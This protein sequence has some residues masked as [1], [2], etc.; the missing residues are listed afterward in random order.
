MPASCGT[1][2]LLGVVA[3]QVEYPQTL[4]GEFPSEYAELPRALISATL[5]GYQKY[6]PLEDAS[7]KLLPCFLAIYD[8]SPEAEANV[9][10]GN[11]SALS[12]RLADAKFF[13][14]H[15]LNLG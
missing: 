12:S 7:G 3:D 14:E 15:D 1:T 2:S 11:Q 13:Y 6:F 5:T 8:S 4:I 10:H 9:R